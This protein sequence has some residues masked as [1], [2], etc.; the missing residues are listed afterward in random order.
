[1]TREELEDKVSGWRSVHGFP[2]E[3]IS[4]DQMSQ[5]VGPEL[6][7]LDLSNVDLSKMDLRC[8]KLLHCSLS[9]AKLNSTRLDG[10]FFF[11]C[12]LSQIDSWVGSFRCTSFQ[13]CYI[14]N[15]RFMH[16]QFE[17][18]SFAHSNLENT[19]LINSYHDRDTWFFRA[20]LRR[21]N[22]Q[23][24]HL[25]KVNMKEV[26]TLFGAKLHLARLEETELDYNL[27]G[28]KVG[29]ELDQEFVKAAQTYSA[30][31]ANLEAA[32]R[33]DQAA[34]AYV[35][36]RQMQRVASA[37]WNVRRLYGATELGDEYEYSQEH[38]RQVRTKLGAKWW[39]PRTWRFYLRHIVKCGSDWIVELLCNYGES[40]WRVLF[41]MGAILFVIGPALIRLLGGLEWTG[42][43]QQVYYTLSNPFQRQ[44]YVYFQY[45]LYMID[46]F[47][48]ADFAKLEPVN[49]FVRLASGFMALL[50]IFL[51]GL[52]GF[53]AGNRIRHS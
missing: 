3:I 53:V 41:W 46:T 23:E 6:S 31:K 16:G 10:A 37:P 19:K 12:D 2:P 50:G 43:N 52:L 24:A 42:D 22:L 9:G 18:A 26:R 27:F 32:G 14:V 15:S 47:T 38:N 40:V 25:E 8:I 13:Q 49:D 28:G 45:V 11:G 34:R 44:A 29:E 51:A 5:Y 39:Q 1:M 30:I 48:T 36:E 17:G 21:T 4:R 7:H 20:R 33:S 35:K